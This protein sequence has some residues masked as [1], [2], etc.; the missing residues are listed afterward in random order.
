MARGVQS[1]TFETPAAFNSS[2]SAILRA[3]Y[4][5]AVASISPIPY[6]GGTRAKSIES[7]AHHGPVLS[8]R[9]GC[10]GLEVAHRKHVL[11]D[12]TP[13]GFASACVELIQTPQLWKELAEAA[14]SFFECNH[15]QGVVDRLL[16]SGF[17]NL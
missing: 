1:V 17:Q 6:G 8:T 3:Y 11:I 7:F 14:Y 4:L 5:Q 13:D 2:L 9:K 10:E 16:V 15:S 12:D